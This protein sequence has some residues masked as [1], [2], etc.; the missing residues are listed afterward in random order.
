MA[1]NS[2]PILVV[3]A[4]AL[5][6]VEGV[7]PNPLAVDLTLALFTRPDVPL[8]GGR[9]GGLT[10]DAMLT[11]LRRQ[12]VDSEPGTRDGLG[13]TEGEGVIKA[14]SIVSK[15]ALMIEAYPVEPTG[16]TGNIDHHN[17]SSGGPRPKSDGTG[18]RPS[19]GLSPPANSGRKSPTS[20]SAPVAFSHRTQSGAIALNV[21]CSAGFTLTSDLV[22]AVQVAVE[23]VTYQ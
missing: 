13:A 21:R 19:P 1:P 3:E 11:E 10:R 4:R 9:Q 18:W 8:V 23:G 2:A 5:V 15:S 22:F 17:L 12:G 16:G 20:I 14:S 6:G 7:D